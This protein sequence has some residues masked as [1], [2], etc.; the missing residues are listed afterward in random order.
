METNIPTFPRVPNKHRRNST[1]AIPS[2]EN[3]LHNRQP[4]HCARLSDLLRP[5]HSRLFSSVR[6]V[7]SS[8]D[9]DSRPTQPWP[10]AL[11]SLP[12]SS[13]ALEYCKCIHFPQ[14]GNRC[15]STEFSHKVCG[16]KLISRNRERYIVVGSDHFC[17]TIAHNNYGMQMLNG[18]ID[19]Y[20]FLGWRRK[21]TVC[22]YSND[23]SIECYSDEF[24]SIEMTCHLSEAESIV[25]HLECIA[26]IQNLNG[27]SQSSI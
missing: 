6:A 17:E 15:V 16:R 14:Q 2:P 20:I 11:Q 5:P 26:W 24:F 7:L 12:A 21:C 4:L 23:L 10:E 19:I 25:F 13:A 9:D 22:I 27:L 8:C 1:A 3:C 18:K